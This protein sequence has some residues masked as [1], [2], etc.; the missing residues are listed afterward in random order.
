MQAVHSGADLE[1]AISNCMGYKSE[2]TRLIGP[3]LARAPFCSYILRGFH[4]INVHFIVPQG[5]GFMVGVNIN[6]VPGLP[7]GFPVMLINSL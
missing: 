6:P 4:A 5:Q 1:S 3:L 2:V 7:A